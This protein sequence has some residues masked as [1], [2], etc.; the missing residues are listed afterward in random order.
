VGE[1]G[2][3]E[4]LGIDALNTPGGFQDDYAGQTGWINE[5]IN[6]SALGSPVFITF[7]ATD[8][9]DSILSSILAIDNIRF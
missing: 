5:T 6:V 2:N 1:D 7:T 8:V 9:E 3:T 4:C